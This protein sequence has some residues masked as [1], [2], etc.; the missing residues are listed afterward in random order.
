MK[1]KYF[2]RILTGLFVLFTAVSCRTLPPTQQYLDALDAAAERAQAARELAMD[3]EAPALFPS[4]WAAADS[5]FAYAEQE[6][7]TETI[8]E[9]QASTERYEIAA[10]A[11]E[12]LA[13]M[14]IAR[15]LENM[16]RDLAQ[17]RIAAVQ[18]GAE[19][20]APDFLS[21]ADSAVAAANQMRQA[22]DFNA[23]RDT[24]ASALAMYGFINA[25]LQAGA[26]REE[27][28]PALEYWSPD[29]L[30]QADT[31]TSDAVQRWDA[32]D[33]NGALATAVQSLSMFTALDAMLQA[34]M[35]RAQV[36]DRVEELTPGALAQA[37]VLAV[38]AIDQW[39][40]GNFNGAQL[41]AANA[42][43]M[44]L[45]AAASAERQLALEARANVAARQEFDSAQAIFTQGNS[46][47]QARRYLEAGRLFNQ[48]TPLFRA[49]AYLAI[50]RQLIAEEALRLANER[51]AESDE[52]AREA[53]RILE[54]DE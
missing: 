17:A 41:A 13:A 19:T 50:E 46:S 24:G 54:G 11:L 31:A 32:G 37:D 2:W 14:T 53:E 1:S 26:I 8:E 43:A 22:G 21:H 20:L 34:Y 40:A 18:A 7:R 12:A 44:Y 51:M 16:E 35:A 39:D 3:F 47:Y 6:R 9:I 38:N 4:D 30:L 28:A 49:S 23:A 48:S 27:I 42:M 29:F 25:L 10:D 45:N 15:S 52:I 5:L 33:Y 36:A